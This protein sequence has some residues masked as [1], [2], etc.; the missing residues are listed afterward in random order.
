[1][2]NVFIN[3]IV[4][5]Q[6]YYKRDPTLYMNYVKSGI[7]NVINDVNKTN[8]HDANKTNIV[9]C[10]YKFIKCYKYYDDMQA[11]NVH[12]IYMSLIISSSEIFQTMFSFIRMLLHMLCIVSGTNFVLVFI[13]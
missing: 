9:Y 6:R 10:T 11:N 7:Y 2:L 1:M 3:G 4:A 13:P 8:M 5:V 12:Y